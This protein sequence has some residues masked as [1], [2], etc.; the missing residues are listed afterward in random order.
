MQGYRNFLFKS[1]TVIN[2][3]NLYTYV[4]IAKYRNLPIRNLHFEY[5]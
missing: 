3:P 2:T 1:K 5:L 4:L